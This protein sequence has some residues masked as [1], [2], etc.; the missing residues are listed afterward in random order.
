[1]SQGV[2]SPLTNNPSVGTFDNNQNSYKA[3][4]LDSKPPVQPSASVGKSNGIKREG[5]GAFKYGILTPSNN[6][7]SSKLPWDQN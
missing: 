6:N 7:G 2:L 4:I 3:S 5:I 1:M